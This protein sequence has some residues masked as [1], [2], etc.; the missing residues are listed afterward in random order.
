MQVV[1]DIAAL[2][3][4]RTQ[5]KGRVGL[6]PTMGYL[7]AGHLSLIRAAREMC[8]AIIGTIFVNPTQFS[9]NEDLSTYPRDLPRDLAMMREAG[10]DLVFT[11]TPDLMYPQH[12]QTWVT[13]TD[14]TQ[15]KEGGK[16]PEHF[17]GVTTVV[18]KLFNLIQADVA[19]F[20]QKDAQQVVAIRQMVRDLNMPI[21]IQVCPIVRESDG[22]ALSSRNVYLRGNERSAAA[23][24]NR[25]LQAAG[26]CYATG[27]R[28]P[29]K[30]REAVLSFVKHEPL[31]QMDYVSLANPHTLEETIEASH[32]PLLLSIAAQVGKPRLLDNC[33]LPL[34]LN[35]QAGATATLGLKS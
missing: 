9:A 27:E 34:T 11:P 7:H 10:I 6:V 25:A 24:L 19:F 30:L 12:F 28:D 5:L 26:D 8:D 17:R 4:H 23:L 14:V 2:R 21:E 3:Q 35:T 32:E 16:R 31:V 33:L 13:V 22:L 20:G 1:D 15:G 29:Q 18:C